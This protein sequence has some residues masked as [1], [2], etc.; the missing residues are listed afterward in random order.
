[1]SAGPAI[2]LAEADRLLLLLHE[3]GPLSLQDIERHLCVPQARTQSTVNYALRKG[4]IERLR[5]RIRPPA[6]DW[7]WNSQAGWKSVFRVA[8]SGARRAAG[9]T[10]TG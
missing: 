9:L 2:L 1:M 3:Q 7:S 10:S 4:Y 8:P 6:T 5:L